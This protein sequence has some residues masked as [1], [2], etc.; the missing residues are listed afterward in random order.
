MV[1]H[2]YLLAR[3]GSK[4][5]DAQGRCM[6]ALYNSDTP[7]GA[8]LEI[9][10]SLRAAGASTMFSQSKLL[11]NF[12]L[13]CKYNYIVTIEYE[14]KIRKLYYLNLRNFSFNLGNFCSSYECIT[15]GLL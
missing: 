2:T 1:K 5:Y 13:A 7:E 6:V 14:I 11:T 12:G 4:A 8:K 15:A 9:E 3:L 10:K